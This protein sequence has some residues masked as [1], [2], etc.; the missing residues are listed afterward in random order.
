MDIPETRYVRRDDGVA[1]AYQVFGDGPVDLLI[2]NGAASHVDLQ[3][4]DPG[5]TRF[6]ARL[7]SFSRVIMF[8]KP[9]TGLSDPIGYVP[10][11]EERVEDI[12]LLL[13]AAGSRE[14]V[15]M[16]ISES[17]A[18]CVLFSA[19]Q[20]ERVRS[21]I[22]Y[23]SYPVAGMPRQP[24]WM[25]DEAFARWLAENP[26]LSARDQEITREIDD[27]VA[28]W[29]EG[30]F[31]D[32]FA[33]SVA[34]RLQRRFWATYERAAASPRMAQA[35]FAASR[36]VDVSEVLPAVSVPTLV[37]HVVDEFIPV[38]CARFLAAGIPGARLVELPGRDHAFWFGD[39]DPIVDEIESFITGM[40][41]PVRPQRALATVLFT[42]I[43][44]SNG[45]VVRPDR[46]AL[47]A[48]CGI[49][50]RSGGIAASPSPRSTPGA[51]PRGAARRRSFGPFSRLRRVPPGATS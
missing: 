44:G 7:A 1:I 27:L 46:R 21:L 48:C 40:R 50:H 25:S 26:D 49:G 34:S 47:S 41:A 14:T 42:D 10:A 43:V 8:D 12:R 28:H 16:G 20:P 30:R 19:T 35:I 32:T 4:T 18:T 45:F 37:L 9:G 22:L 39:F 36:E 51:W 5:L 6:L 31:V 11:L 13:D 33:P 15:L 3:W 2:A 24:S 29:G 38:A 23:G 17:G